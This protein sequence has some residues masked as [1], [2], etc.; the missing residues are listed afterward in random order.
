MNRLQLELVKAVHDGRAGRLELE[1]EHAS[2]QQQIASLQKEL[3][4][5]RELKPPSVSF[6]DLDTSQRPD[7]VTIGMV[8]MC[9]TEESREE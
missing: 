5:L 7:S 8:Y 1:H 2:Q 9:E 3:K 4:M 6:S